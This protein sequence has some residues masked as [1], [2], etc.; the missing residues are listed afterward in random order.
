MRRNNDKVVDS[1][2]L[3]VLKR[4]GQPLTS[5]FIVASVGLCEGSEEGFL[6]PLKP[7]TGARRGLLRRGWHQS[8]T[9][10]EAS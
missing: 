10:Y 7:A 4:S 1:C 5:R 9:Y 6:L 3:L 8:I 2:L